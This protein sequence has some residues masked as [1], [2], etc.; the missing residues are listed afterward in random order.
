MNQRLSEK[1]SMVPDAPGVYL[2][3]DA[4]GTVIYVGKARSLKKRLGSYFRASGP[5]DIKTGVMVGKIDAFETILTASEKEALILEETLIKR[6]RPRY[7]VILKDDKRYPSLRLD[8]THPWPN[9]TVVRKIRNDGARYFGPYASAQAVRETLNL[10]NKTF[11]LRK[12]K[13]REMATRT[14]PCLHHQM[15]RCLAPCCL[16]VDSEAYRETV[17]EVTLFLRGRTRDLVLQIRRRMEKAAAAQDFEAAATLRDRMFALERTLERQVVVTNDFVDRDV[18]VTARSEVLTVVTVMSVRGGSLVGSRHFDGPPS[19]G[20]D[21]EI[22][23]SFIRQYYE[24]VPFIP[25]S[26]L[27][28]D[29]PEETALL[30]SWL[31][32]RKG[33]R[34][35]LHRPRRGEKFRLLQLARQNAAN[36][37]EERLEART[38]ERELLTRLQKHLAMERL[39]RRIECID[40]SNTAG[41]A[42]VSARVV[43]VDGRAE[44]SAYRTYGIETVTGPDDY[45][46]MAEVL[47]RRFRDMAS[48]PLPDLM[49]IDGGRGQLSTAV[50]VLGEMGFDGRFT[51]AGIAKK[52]EARGEPLDRIFLPG[53]V[54]PV[55]FGRDGDLLLFLQRIRDEAH[56]FAIAFH[57]KRRGRAAIRSAL[58][59]IAGIGPKRKAMLL[60][61]YGH[62]DAIRHA[63]VEE[64]ADLPGMTPRLA[65]NLK[66]G[67]ASRRNGTP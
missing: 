24:S 63:A 34:V 3:K 53:R 59:N 9:L 21:G 49:L 38:G 7:N 13:N 30:E 51:V 52:D 58:D 35:H 42:P 6:H 5:S 25:S 55:Q 61:R 26:V 22:L 67:L 40:N 31:G 46:T 14:R 15:D 64:I 33:R 62:V 29:L 19:P 66:D 50:S 56:R 43:F 23:S 65:Q 12:C 39:P 54:N 60:A 44:K 4:Q 32:E 20:D 57:R 18:L 47:R 17:R 16:P 45:A 8:T 1:L 27:M 10:I 41:T 48:E 11:R 36:A 37:L 2:M 28:G